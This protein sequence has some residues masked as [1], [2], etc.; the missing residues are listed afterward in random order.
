MQMKHRKEASDLV[1]WYFWQIQ[2]LSD[3]HHLGSSADCKCHGSKKQLKNASCLFGSL[4]EQSLGKPRSQS[5][6]EE[7]S[8]LKV[9]SL[10]FEHF[11]QIRPHKQV[12]QLW[13]AGMNI[14]GNL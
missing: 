2:K 14:L 8:E 1:W 12:K 7:T 6:R 3:C 9:Q 5:E 11:E 13:R 10:I 4:A